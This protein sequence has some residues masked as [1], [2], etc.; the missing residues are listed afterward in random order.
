[1][2]FV[3]NRHIVAD[4][5][6]LPGLEEMYETKC[7]E[8]KALERF[9]EKLADRISAARNADYIYGNVAIS[10]L[11]GFFCAVSSEIPRSAEVYRNAN[12]EKRWG[13]TLSVRPSAQHEAGRDKWFGADWKRKKDAVA[14]AME[15]IAYG[16]EPK[17][18]GIDK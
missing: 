14:A 17:F 9:I 18:N 11:D 10:Q 12:N 15:W 2:K 7:R 16:K 4:V 5:D 13:L 6:K 3:E 8:L 1:M